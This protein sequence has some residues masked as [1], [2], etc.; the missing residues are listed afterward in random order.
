MGIRL[1][2]RAARRPAIRNYKT[3]VVHALNLHLV[4]RSRDE[5]TTR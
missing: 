2:G 5:I 3:L 1:H 4:R